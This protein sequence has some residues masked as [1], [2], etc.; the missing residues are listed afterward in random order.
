MEKDKLVIGVQKGYGKS[1]VISARLPQEL[2][3]GLDKIA[4]ET[5]R[6]RSEIVLLCVEF[7]LPKIEI[8]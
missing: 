4:L 1:S 5:G 6:T 8:R 7:S 2:I 3:D